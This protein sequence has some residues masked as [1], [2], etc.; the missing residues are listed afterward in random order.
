MHDPRH[1]HLMGALADQMFSEYGDA[2]HDAVQPRRAVV[3][4]NPP[5][6]AKPAAK[7]APRM[8]AKKKT[9]LLAWLFGL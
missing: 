4:T 7:P 8:Q 2:M 1:V 9:G 5:A 3:R 6:A